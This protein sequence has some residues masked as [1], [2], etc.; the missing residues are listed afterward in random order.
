MLGQTA[1]APEPAPVTVSH[2][3]DTDRTPAAIGLIGLGTMGAMLALNIAEKGFGIA[4]FNRTETVTDGFVRDAGALAARITPTTSLAGLVAARA[5]PRK[6]I[7]MVP[8]GEVVDQ[9]IAAL[10]PL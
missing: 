7:L 6:I 8:A 10:R 5:R 9:Q 3:T 1:S 2:Q 4:V